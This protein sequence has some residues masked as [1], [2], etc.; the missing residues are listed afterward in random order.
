MDG[1]YSLS[2]DALVKLISTIRDD[3]VR[4]YKDGTSANNGERDDIYY[5]CDYFEECKKCD[6]L[7]C[8]LHLNYCENC[9]NFFCKSHKLLKNYCEKC[10]TYSCED[11]THT[12]S[13]L[14][15]VIK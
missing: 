11:Y 14:K 15:F 7:V 3:T 5:N 10:E 6:K 12:C 9:G 1:L 13:H 4:K 2:K 8:N